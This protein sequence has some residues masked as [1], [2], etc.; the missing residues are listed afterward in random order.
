MP[1]LISNSTINVKSNEFSAKPQVYSSILMKE[2]KV[3]L[4]PTSFYFSSSFVGRNI[5]NSTEGK[6]VVLDDSAPESRLNSLS[7]PLISDSS[8]SHSPKLPSTSLTP[9]DNAITTIPPKSVSVIPISA[10]ESSWADLKSQVKVLQ[11]PMKAGEINNANALTLATVVSSMIDN[12]NTF[13]RPL[14]P[15]PANEASDSR[16][17]KKA[18]TNVITQSSI[19]SS[20]VVDNLSSADSPMLMMLIPASLIRWG[21][22]WDDSQS[23]G[24]VNGL[25]DKLH[26]SDTANDTFFSS[27]TADSLWVE[28]GCTVIKA[29]LLK[30]VTI[31]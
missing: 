13:N 26:K 15:P 1:S 3:L 31:L 29:Q 30:N 7:L 12:K 10:P 19:P 16:L 9:N 22:S 8:S 23:T 25:K 4:D 11:L 24:F 27:S 5:V 2:G 21:T 17:S 20:P 28:I 6:R 18:T 14:L